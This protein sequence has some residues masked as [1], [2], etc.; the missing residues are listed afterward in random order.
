[1][2]HIEPIIEVAEPAIGMQVDPG[3]RASSHPAHS[4]T[5]IPFQMGTP[6]KVLARVIPVAAS[7]N[8]MAIS[9]VNTKPTENALEHPSRSWVRSKK[10]DTL[11]V[12]PTATANRN[13]RTSVLNTYNPAYAA[14]SGFQPPGARGDSPVFTKMSVRGP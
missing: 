1:M 7:P 2:F 12:K 4:P 3:A 11:L 13:G 8:H 5:Q 10:F 9:A 14:K 6:A